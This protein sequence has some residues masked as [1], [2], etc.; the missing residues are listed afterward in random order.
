CKRGNEWHLC[1]D[2]KV[3]NFY[4]SAEKRCAQLCKERPSVFHRVARMTTVAE[5]QGEVQVKVEKTD[6]SKSIAD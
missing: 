2:A 5:L 3:F 4:A 1:D 6:G